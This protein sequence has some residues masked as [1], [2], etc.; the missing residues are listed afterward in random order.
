MKNFKSL[1]IFIALSLFFLA[2][3]CSNAAF[4][5]EEALR[6]EVFAIHDAVMPRMS[7]IVKL[8]GQLK[9]L[10]AD[11]IK[12]LEAN[13]MTNQL[14]KAEDGMMDWMNQFTQLEKLRETKKHD[15][16]VAYLETEKL[17]IA[18]VRD[19]MNG[20]IAAAARLVNAASGQ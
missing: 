14:E 13:A 12:A 10:Q 4:E 5:K 16:I 8:K 15:E 1:T 9:E 6:D 17:R 2:N 3:S 7:E 18:K 20:G 11:S 19:D